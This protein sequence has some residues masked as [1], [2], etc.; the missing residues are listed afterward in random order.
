MSKIKPINIASLMMLVW[1]AFYVFAVFFAARWAEF[2][3]IIGCTAPMLIFKKKHRGVTYGASFCNTVRYKKGEYALYFL[4]C[5]SGC[6]LLSAFCYLL[7]SDGEAAVQSARTDFPYML[8]FGCFLPA[9]FEEWLVRGGVLGALSPYKAAGVW[10]SSIFFMLMHADPTKYLYALFAGFCIGT[11]VYLT[12]CIYIGM[13]LHF[14]NNL[15]SLLL[16]YLPSG[17]AEKAALAIIALVFCV[18]FYFLKRGKLF[19]DAAELLKK[20]KE[21]DVILSPLFYIFVLL[22]IFVMSFRFI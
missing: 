20:G 9:F 10:T 6:A 16:S 19:L 21:Q 12:E 2:L 4:F 14:I 1:L 8:V 7:F 17:N 13:L 11:L 18:S 3:V 22:S 5:I 15:T